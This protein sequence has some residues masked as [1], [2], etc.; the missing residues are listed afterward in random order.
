MISSRVYTHQMR[1][2]YQLF[3]DQAVEGYM[4]LEQFV[5]LG[6]IIVQMIYSNSYPNTVRIKVYKDINVIHVV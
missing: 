4:T 5:P 1:E 3:N 2:L 6:R